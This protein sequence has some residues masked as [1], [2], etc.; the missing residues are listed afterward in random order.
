MCQTHRSRCVHVV[1]YQINANIPHSAFMTVREGAWRLPDR[2]DVKPNP[3]HTF[4]L[5]LMPTMSYVPMRI[6][7]DASKYL[8]EHLPSTST[9]IS[10]ESGR[11]QPTTS[12]HY[13]LSQTATP[14]PTLVS[15]I[16]TREK[17]SHGKNVWKNIS[18]GCGVSM[19]GS[20]QDHSRFSS[21]STHE[22]YLS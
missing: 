7:P 4:C 16:G 5:W 11:L 20:G 17:C 14:T 8:H 22:E 9:T 18:V 19:S 10:T 6:R 21:W 1:F 13:I 15:T 2:T 3:V 12:Q